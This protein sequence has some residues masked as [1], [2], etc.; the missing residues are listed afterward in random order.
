[1]A[2]IQYVEPNTFIPETLKSIPV[3]EVPAGAGHTG[4]AIINRADFA[5]LAAGV[6]TRAATNT[7]TLIAGYVVAS[8]LSGFAGNVAPFENKVFGAGQGPAVIPQNSGYVTLNP[9]QQIYIEINATATTG[10]QTGGAQQVDI[11]STG[12][13]LLDT[14]TNLFVFDP[15][16]ANK[17]MTI[18]SKPLGPNKGVSGDLGARFVVQFSAASLI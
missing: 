5:T 15:T 6:L 7:A 9:L 16:Q 12:G 11:G 1:M 17:I 2:L 18:Y 10:Y 13:L 4:L 3:R 14:T 8:E